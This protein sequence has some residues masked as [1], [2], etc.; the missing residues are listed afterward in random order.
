MTRVWRF[1]LDHRLAVPIGVIVAL[2][3][4]NAR[5]ESYFEFSVDLSF[6]VNNV[7]MALFFALVTQEVIE[8]MVPG[9]ALH[10]WRRAALPIVAAIG[11]TIGAIAVYQAFVYWG[12]EPLL[13]AGWPIVCAI[14]GG[15]TYFLARALFGRHRATP[16]LLFLVIV[17]DAIGLTT[18]GLTTIGFHQPEVP[19]HLAAGASAI[20]AGLG[21]S[22]VLAR[23]KSATFWPHLLISGTLLWW[24]FHWSG[25]HPALALIPIVPFLP[26]APRGLDL[27][28]DEGPH[29]SALHLEHALRLPVQLVLFLF[30]LVNA[31][32]LERGYGPGTWAVL[33]GAL[34]GRPL[35]ILAAAGLSR[36]IGLRLPPQVGW[37]ELSVVAFIASIGF[38]FGLFLAT[39]VFPVGP[40][41]MELKMGA[42]LTVAGTLVATAAAW[43]LGTGRFRT[44]RAL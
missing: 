4:A 24:G 12:D 20:A 18:I 39:A 42:L 3:W 7:G 8:A 5:A 25:L 28:A 30:A 16:F 35:G 34:A 41:L 40:T 31:G 38:T 10:T 26:R 44:R 33:A 43:L 23:L 11:G 14:D 17:T 15:F 13:T 36:M 21:A 37:R 29:Q 6:L 22:L 2:L 27:L 32:I 1:V 19:L 9:G